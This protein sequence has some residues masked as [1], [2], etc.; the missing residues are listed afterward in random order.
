MSNDGMA[1]IGR[2]AEASEPGVAVAAPSIDDTGVGVGFPAGAP[3]VDGDDVPAPQ[4]ARMSAIGMSS[5]PARP[6]VRRSVISVSPE[7]PVEVPGP[8]DDGTGHP[9]AQGGRL[10]KRRAPAP[11][12]RAA[13]RVS[14][15]IVRST[16]AAVL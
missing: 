9:M 8:T 13:S 2:L 14:A 12:D 3:E 7:L 5:V 1:P 10:P 15:S 4:A 6:A 16:S 11:Q